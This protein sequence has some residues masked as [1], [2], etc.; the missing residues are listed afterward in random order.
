MGFIKQFIVKQR[1]MH[2]QVNAEKSRR[3]TNRLKSRAS[4]SNTYGDIRRSLKQQ[5]THRR[6]YGAY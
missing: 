1:I 4:K 3:F 5:V 6:K 2:D